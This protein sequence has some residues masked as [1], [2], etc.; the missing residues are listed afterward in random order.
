[1]QFVQLGGGQLQQLAE[2][3]TAISGSTTNV[4]A[5]A[6]IRPNRVVECGIMFD[7]ENDV[8]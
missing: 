7:I 5:K 2:R 8:H 4:V 3:I 1:M 6:T